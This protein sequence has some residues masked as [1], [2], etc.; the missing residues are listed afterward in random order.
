MGFSRQ[1]Y[2]SGLPF[3]PPGDPPDSGIEPGS[4]ALQAYS[5]PTELQGKPH[6]VTHMKCHCKQH[7]IKH[8][9]KNTATYEEKTLF[10][11]TDYPTKLLVGL[12]VADE[13]CTRLI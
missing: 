5:L 1:E 8:K 6:T 11:V 4:P 3:P 10:Q 13:S 12:K 9:S 2:W 7:V